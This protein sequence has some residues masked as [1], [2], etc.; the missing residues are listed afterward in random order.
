MRKKFSLTL[1]LL[2][3]IIA[4]VASTLICDVGLESGTL[5][6]NKYGSS[7]TL[8]NVSP[9][10]GY[11]LFAPMAS[12]IAYLIDNS[13]EVIHTWE[14]DYNPA[15]SVYLLENGSIL[16]TASLGLPSDSTFYFG[17]GAGGLVQKFDWNGTV[18]WE[19]EYSNNQH[20]LHHDIKALPD[21]NVLMIAWE[22][23]TGE[24]A[25]AAGRDP[26]LL[27]EGELWPDHIIEVEPNGAIGGN[28]VWEWH[29]WDHLIQDYNV[30]A[31]NYGVVADHPELIDINFCSRPRWADWTHINSID[32]NE[33]F[34]QILLSVNG[35]TEIWVIDHS[36]T[37]EEAAGH[38]GGNSGKGGDILFRWGN[39]QAYRAG[40]AS[41]EKFFKQHDAQW[42]GSGYPGEGNILVFNNGNNRP[43]GS[44]SSV[45]EI[46]PPVDDNGNYFMTP[47]SAYGPEEQTWIYT[48]ENPTDFYSQGVSG[49][50]RLP[51]GNTLICDGQDGLF[52]EVTPEKNIV[53][54]YTN[55][56]PEEAQNNVFKVR[57]YGPDFP[58]LL[59]LISPHDVAI[60]NVTPDNTMVKPGH[61]V[62]IEVT[63]ENQGSHTEMFNVTAYADTTIIDMLTDMI[64][65]SG[66]STTIGFAWNTTAFGNYTISAFASPVPG[67][68]DVIDNTFV[69]SWVIV[70]M[71]GDVDGD[72][73][74]DIF[75]IFAIAGSYG[76]SYPNPKYDPNCD[77]NGDG[78]IDTIDVVIVAG[79]YGQSWEP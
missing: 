15:L 3:A 24:E 32:Y 23:K 68:I 28:I 57:R 41:D 13:G 36:T 75:D 73:D 27:A 44:Y 60:T 52:F 55:Q 70:T 79:N 49:V 69:G 17:G 6:S 2:V 14:S 34:D 38:S 25:V 10:D 51:N 67:E 33:E 62:A 12:T 26:R 29:V 39:P 18:I 46:V 59:D 35:F 40:D 66:N 64:L 63:I 30:T 56:F 37:T 22:Y 72:N 20:L 11:T 31:E 50:Q 9:F 48:A 19:F 45:D 58:G 8:M 1:L 16:R 61:E 53:W 78:D 4:F 71:P 47:G 77:I 5:A 21:G 65:T 74:V 42:I 43:D 54:E 7:L 76:A